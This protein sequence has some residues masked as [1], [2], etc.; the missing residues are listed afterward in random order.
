MRGSAKSLEQNAEQPWPS[1]PPHE[2]RE[3]GTAQELLRA[4]AAFEGWLRSN[5]SS[6]F[7]PYD[8]WGRGTGWRRGGFTTPGISLAFP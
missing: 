6:S 8:V 7:D 1:S 3:E 2:I 4:I 5:G